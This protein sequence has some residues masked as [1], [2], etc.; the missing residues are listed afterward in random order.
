MELVPPEVLPDLGITYSNSYRLR[1]EKLNRF[2]KRVRLSPVRY[3]Y[4]R[5]EIME[6]LAGLVAA[7]DAQANKAA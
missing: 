3:A 5:A 7:R 2:P 1:Q 6:Y 4:V